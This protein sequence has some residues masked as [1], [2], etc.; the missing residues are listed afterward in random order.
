MQ[1]PTFGRVRKLSHFD[2]S[3][4]TA[5]SWPV[6]SL[7]YVFV[8]AAARTWPDFPG[9]PSSHPRAQKPH[10]GSAT[11]PTFGAWPTFGDC[12]SRINLGQNIC[13]WQS[14]AGWDVLLQPFG[15]ACSAQGL[16]D[17]GSIRAAPAAPPQ[18]IPDV[19]LAVFWKKI[20]FSSAGGI[21]RKGYLHDTCFIPSKLL[22]SRNWLSKTEQNWFYLLCLP[23]LKDLILTKVHFRKDD[24]IST[25]IA[26]LSWFTSCTLASLCMTHFFSNNFSKI[27]SKLSHLDA[28]L[29]ITHSISRLFSCYQIIA[30]MSSALIPTNLLM[31]FWGNIISPAQKE[32][33]KRK[34]EMFLFLREISKC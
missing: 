19:S 31:I 8:A 10:F 9:S 20:Q 15:S 24:C 6:V 16:L 17:S 33:D 5:A 27:N 12:T 4:L 22:F 23:I 7:L 18:L 21:E 34:G 32:K 26:E 3:H 30:E 28:L 13:A 29:A 11:S 1:P 2:V 14:L 25:R